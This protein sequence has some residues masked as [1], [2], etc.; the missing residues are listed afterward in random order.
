[1]KLNN[2]FQASENVANTHSWTLTKHDMGSS[3][4]DSLARILAEL[5]ME[6]R[7]RG[8]PQY[9]ELWKQ[10]LGGGEGPSGSAADA[11]R[12]FIEPVFGLPEKPDSVPRDH[13]EGY[14]A[15]YL[16]YFLSL[17]G[18]AGE[19]V[20]RIEPPGFTATDPGGDGLIIHRYTSVDLMFRL[21]EIKKCTGGSKVSLTVGNA[22]RQLNAK[23]TEYLARYTTIGQEIPDAKLADFYGQ[24]IDLWIDARPEAAAG[25]SVTTSLALVPSRCFTTFGK[26][27]P[28]FANPVRLRGML[29]AIGDF[30]EFVNKVREYVWTGLLTPS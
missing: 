8:C 20:V 29:T 15:E 17:E 16:W 14:V 5:I 11:L 19:N 30:P 18:F 28:K 12:A 13:L 23:A 3:D 10:R 9:Y 26:R 1:M 27:F 25:V 7:C 6:H 24:L 22:Y 2:F 4:V 21:W